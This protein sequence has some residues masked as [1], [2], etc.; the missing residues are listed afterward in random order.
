MK[1]ARKVAVLQGFCAFITAFRAFVPDGPGGN[2]TRK[3][4]AKNVD[5]MLV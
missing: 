3:K 5:F 1:K 2:R 4:F